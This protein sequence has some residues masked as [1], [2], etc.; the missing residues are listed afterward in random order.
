MGSEYRATDIFGLGIPNGKLIADA[1]AQQT[2]FAV[3]V[4]DLFDGAWV[5]A[6]SLKLIE[7]PIN[8]APLLAKVWAYARMIASFIWVS[9]GGGGAREREWG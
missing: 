6:D 4:P 2:G 8:R 7:Q 3:Y 9:I 5:P 1:L